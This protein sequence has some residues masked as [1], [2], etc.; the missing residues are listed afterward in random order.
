MEFQWTEA[1]SSE[2]VN[3]KWTQEQTIL[4]ITFLSECYDADTARDYIH[5]FIKIAEKAPEI[6]RFDT[7]TDLSLVKKVTREGRAASLEALKHPKSGH[8]AVY[9]LGPLTKAAMKFVMIAA[10]KKNVTV[11]DSLD[12]G[13]AWI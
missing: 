3:I 10:R 9:G 8:S 12:E 6:G 4:H 2:L 13:L 5:G 1:Y 7:V 11:C